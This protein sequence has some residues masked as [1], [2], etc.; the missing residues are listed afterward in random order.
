M[1]S[2]AK[3]KIVNPI[4]SKKQTNF[5]K[6]MSAGFLKVI[7]YKGFF[8]FFLTVNHT[9]IYIVF[10]FKKTKIT[11]AE[12]KSRVFFV[13]GNLQPNIALFFLMKKRHSVFGRKTQ[14]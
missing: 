1:T 4:F 12:R 13:H 2:L 6:I 11:E 9:A 3:K 10:F 5:H 7:T 14:I 8:C